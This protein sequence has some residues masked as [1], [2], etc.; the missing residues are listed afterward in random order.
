[1]PRKTRR[2]GSASRSSSTAPGQ[3]SSPAR[4]PAYWRPL[5]SGH[6]QPYGGRARRRLS[7]DGGYG[8]QHRT[9]VA[10]TPKVLPTDA[11]SMVLLL[12][13]TSKNRSK[14]RDRKSTRL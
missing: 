9:C 6:P 7:K 8:G 5:A 10:H 3:L 13:S 1:M 11:D 12:D 14:E 2:R 4:P